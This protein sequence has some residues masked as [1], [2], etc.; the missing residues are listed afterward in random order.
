MKQGLLLGVLRDFLMIKRGVFFVFF[1]VVD[2]VSRF[3]HQTG[4][5]FLGWLMFFS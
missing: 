3:R 5:A 1:G 4:F 2:V